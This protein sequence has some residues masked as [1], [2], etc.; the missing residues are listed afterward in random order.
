VTWLTWDVLG[1]ALAL[2]FVFEGLMPF[3]AP[4]IWRQSFQQAL[5]LD[6]GQLRFFGLCSI[7]I[8]LAVLFLLS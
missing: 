4:A 1:L 8:G 3:L 7:L 6:D 5:K 2:V